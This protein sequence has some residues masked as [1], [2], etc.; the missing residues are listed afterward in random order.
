WLQANEKPQTYGT[1]ASFTFS[2]TQTAGFNAAGT[3]QTN[4]SNA[5]ASYL[6]GAVNSASVVDA[7]VSSVGGRL[8]PFGWWVQDN[9]KVTPRLTLNLGMRHDLF[10]T[11]VEVRNRMSWLN[12]SAPNPAIG[13]FPGILTFAGDG[14][15]G[16]HCRNDVAMY[17]RA[18]G[19]RIGFAYSLN[20][21]T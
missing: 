11:W 10:T 16:C 18:F 13:G 12:P 3:L 14:P 4:T 5:Y 6:L 20:G 1:T 15:N 2:N 19:P 7:W 8:R 17:R 21:K 9:F